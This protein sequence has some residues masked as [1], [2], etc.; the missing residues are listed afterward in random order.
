LG[1]TWKCDSYLSEVE[2]LF[3]NGSD[4]L[5]QAIQNSPCLGE[6]FR[7]CCD[8]VDNGIKTSISN[9]RA[10]K[11]RYESLAKPGARSVLFLD[12]FIALADEMITDDNAD[13]VSTA[14]KFL[15]RV[16]SEAH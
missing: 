1:R 8:A 6:R 15:C 10:A 7:L 4:C 11:H 13:H 12:A 14:G 3:I 2:A 16:D 9:L 5:T